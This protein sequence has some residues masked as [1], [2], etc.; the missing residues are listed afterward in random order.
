MYNQSMDT[1]AP[2]ARKAIRTAEEAVLQARFDG[3]LDGGASMQAQ[4]WTA[5]D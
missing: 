1:Q 2:E 3:G 4:D 5:G